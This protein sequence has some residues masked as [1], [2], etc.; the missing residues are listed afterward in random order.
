MLLKVKHNTAM[1]P[2]F[3]LV[4]H[5]HFPENSA[6]V[7]DA[8]TGATPVCFN[9]GRALKACAEHSELEEPRLSFN[10]FDVTSGGSDA[11]P[12]ATNASA[13]CLVGTS[14]DCS[15]CPFRSSG[16]LPSTYC[17]RHYGL[18]EHCAEDYAGIAET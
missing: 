3:S 9:G 14:Q 18:D 4:L 12:G 17:L 13:T 16:C 11:E 10:G 6:S 2:E 15:S 1:L 7:C 8:R 5:A